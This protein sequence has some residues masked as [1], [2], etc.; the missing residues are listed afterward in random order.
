MQKTPVATPGFFICPVTSGLTRKS[1]HPS[2]Q[3]KGIAPTWSGLITTTYAKGRQSAVDIERHQ[4]FALLTA[5]HEPS[6]HTQPQKELMTTWQY[7]GGRLLPPPNLEDFAIPLRS[8]QAPVARTREN[9]MPSLMQMIER[10]NTPSRHPQSYAE[11]YEHH[12]A[13][14]MS[15]SRAH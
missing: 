3:F 5:C 14:A 2:I 9:E 6:D 10:W 11:P 1:G 7:G 13:W 4:D 12:P 15:A 8:M